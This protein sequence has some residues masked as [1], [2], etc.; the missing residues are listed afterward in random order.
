MT[1]RTPGFFEGAEM[2][3]AGWW[4]ALWP[5]PRTVL[6]AVGMSAGTEVI[7]LCSGD[8]WFTLQIARIARHVTAIDL[9]G[10]LL[11]VARVR[12]AESGITNVSFVVGNAYD[13]ASLVSQSVD[14]VFLANAFHGDPHPTINLAVQFTLRDAMVNKPAIN[15]T[16]PSETIAFGA[17][18]RR[19]GG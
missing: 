11:E 17:A 1:D 19:A 10:T 15:F 12:L 5:A 7:D 13:I 2:P 4:E 16:P 18:G 9:D 6:V 3:A 8:G 14:F